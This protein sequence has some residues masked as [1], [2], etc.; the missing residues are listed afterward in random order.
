MLEKLWTINTSVNHFV[1][2]PFMLALLLGIGLWLTIRTGFLPIRKCGLIFS[3]TIGSLFQKQDRSKGITPFQAVSTALAGTLGVGS[4]VGVATAITAGGPGA[5]F[6]MWISALFGMMIKYGEVILSVHF[7]NRESD[8]T[9]IGGP[10]TTL[11][12]GCHMKFLGV[13]FALLCIFAS[14]GIGNAAPSNT[15]AVTFHSYFGVNPVIC[16]VIAA[17]LIGIVIIGKAGRIM[18]VN[19]IFVPVL[20]IL[21]IGAS[22]YLIGTRAEFIAPAFQMI[23]KDAFTLPSAAGGIGGYMISRAMHY[24]ISRGVF[25]NEAGMGSAPIAHASVAEVNAVEQG[26]WGIFEVFFDTIVICTISA[27]VIMTSPYFGSALDGVQMTVM[28]FVDGFGH[29]GGVLFAFAIASFALS[30]I[31]GWY[32]YAVQCI[33]YLFTSPIMLVIYKVLFLVVIVAGACAH[34]D[35]VWEI[36]DTLNGLMSIPNLL[37]L[38]LLYRIILRY[39][40][41][42]LHK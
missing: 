20:S 39:T 18:R 9:Y 40:N 28:C 22:L 5:V 36:A 29:W 1:W 21:Y 12:N 26:F 8:G 16:G 38:I 30:S 27:M 37:S 41:D 4:V 7:R 15:I 23:L 42:Y 13:L 14:F 6:W 17:I 10:M 2:G 34:L 32:F 33:R 25:S 3:K 31:L 35:L 24:G 11:E 19:E